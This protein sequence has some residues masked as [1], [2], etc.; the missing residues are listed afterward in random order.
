M[1]ARIVVIDSDL[2]FGEQVAEL[3][4]RLGV[5]VETIAD[6]NEGVQLVQLDPPAAVV[7]GV[8]DDRGAGYALCS[9]LRR[10]LPDLPVAMVLAP[11]ELD[12]DRLE[13][14][15]SLRTHA[16]LY[17]ER[18]FRMRRLFNFLNE[19]LGERLA[20]PSESLLDTMIGGQGPSAASFE[21]VG[22]VIE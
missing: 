9:K 2:E 7:I 10:R 22:D 13:R 14:H 15:Q 17:L 4:Q 20:A 8:L 16:D 1:A 18:P 19:S 3:C 5:E 11:D 12:S 6:G 21:V